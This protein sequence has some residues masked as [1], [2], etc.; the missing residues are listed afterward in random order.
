MSLN[1]VVEWR[2]GIVLRN[3]IAP[4]WGSFNDSGRGG[5]KKQRRAFNQSSLK[6]N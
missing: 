5:G 2:S 3:E 1:D 6:E 4:R